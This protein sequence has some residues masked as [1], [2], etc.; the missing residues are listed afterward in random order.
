MRLPLLVLV[1]TL[2]YAHA[3]D[4]HMLPDPA[5][6][7]VP[8]ARSA[9]EETAVPQI[10]NGVPTTAYPSV[11]AL[12]I[13]NPTGEFLCT[14]TLVSPSVILTAA[15]CVA[16][17][18]VA[19]DAV[20]FPNSSTE[21][22]YAVVAY[23]IHPEYRFPAA[24][25]AMLLLEAPVVGITPVPLAGR[26]PRPRTVST[27]VGYGADEVGNMGVKQMGT[28]RL[29]RCPRRVPALGLQPGDLA[30]ALCWRA[31][32]W[33]QDTCHGDSGGPL[34]VGG[35]LAGVTSGGDANCSGF[36]SWD[37]SVVP[38]RPWIVSLLR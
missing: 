4:W 26:T 37:T 5:V 36:L 11:A 24:D 1:T 32:P 31:R 15:H 9:P 6:R 20:F 21:T 22:P 27:I 29:R 14:G 3:A 18:P 28:V 17:D 34:L 10:I 12:D 38:F 13:W 19:I 30:R 16:N 2:G 25:V 33:E 7:A 23:A 8:Q 35:V